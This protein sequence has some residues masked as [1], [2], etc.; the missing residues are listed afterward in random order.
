MEQLLGKKYPEGIIVDEKGFRSAFWLDMLVK[1]GTEVAMLFMAPVY[2]VGSALT[3]DDPLDV[4]IVVVFSHKQWWKY[5][6]C[7]YKNYQELY[8]NSIYYGPYERLA[9]ITKKQKHFVEG[10]LGGMPVD[11]KI[12]WDENFYNPNNKGL[13]VRIDQLQNVI[14]EDLCLQKH[15]EKNLSAK[16]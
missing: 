11:F 4:D 16:N 7:G 3:V 12:Q 14:K 6:G 5:I 15:K 1:A 9:R 8:H 2:L 13:R 10:F